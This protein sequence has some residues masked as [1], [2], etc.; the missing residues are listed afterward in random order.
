[1]GGKYAKACW[2]RTALENIVTTSEVNSALSQLQFLK[3]KLRW[4]FI[5]PT[6]CLLIIVLVWSVTFS[7]LATE[8][9]N[10]RKQ[11]FAEAYSLSKSYAEQLSRTVEQVDQITLNVSYYWAESHGALRLEK[12]ANHGLYPTKGFFSIGITDKDGRVLTSLRNSPGVASI[13]DRPYFQAHKNNRISGLHIERLEQ[14]RVTGK[15]IVIVSRSLTDQAGRFAGIVYVAVPPDFLASFYD[16]AGEGEHDALAVVTLDGDFIATK[17][18]KSVRDYGSIARYPAVFS[19]RHGTIAVSENDFFDKRSRIVAWTAL[20]DY[21]FVSVVALDEKEAYA[22]Y[23]TLKRDYTGMAVS[24]TLLLVLVAAIG[25]VLSGRLIWRKHQATI[26]SE[27]YHLAIEGAREGF[28]MARALYSHNQEI[29][30]FVLENFNEHGAQMLG[31]RKE[32][33]AGVRFTQLYAGQMAKRI[34]LIFRKAMHDGFY[35]DEFCMKREEGKVWMHR[36][37]VRSGHGIAITLRDI[38]EAK[39]HERALEELANTDA[40][41]KLPNRYWLSNHLSTLLQ[42]AERAQSNVAVLYFDLDEF[43]DVNNTIGHDAGDDVLVQVGQRIQSVL[44]PGDH[45]VRLGGDEFTVVLSRIDTT[46]DAVRVA[47]RVIE[48]LSTPFQVVGGFEA[49]VGTSI[50]I[51]LYPE[52][53]RTAETLLTHAD[54]AMYAAKNNGKGRF[55]FYSPIL[56]ERTLHR[57]NSEHALRR[58][59]AESQFVL[60]YQPRVAALTGRLVSMEALVRWKHPERGLVPPLDFIPL[61]EETGLI[62][63]IGELVIAQACAQ[64]SEWQENGLKAVP[65]SVNV[66]PIQFARR[67]LRSVIAANISRYGISASMIEVE[68]TESCMLQDS[69]KVALD[70]AGLKTLGIR[71]SVDDFGTGYSSLAQLQRLDIDVLKIDRAFT[72][73][74]ANGK[75]GEAFFKTIVTMAHILDMQVVAEGVETLEQLRIIQ[76][77]GCNEIQGYFVSRPLPAAEAT[78]LLGR[79]TLFPV[80]KMPLRSV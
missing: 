18:G 51:S 1:V 12:Q 8:K 54:T 56:T 78:L 2:I 31:F 32:Q 62:V 11:A 44:R 34:M 58:A 76:S 9:A 43:K 30:D 46:N 74:L 37:L 67:D 59:V 80:G 13:A 65:L 39:R 26:V 73:A 41:T 6:V 40:L 15:P 4:L 69:E 28:F 25:T 68:I 17:M 5:W 38:T 75:H 50:G 48:V 47:N 29:S 21:S 20:D 27:T 24:A 16:K 71:V 3:G 61:A 60:Y 22:T 79:R 49:R 14:G 53:G 70:I 72:E 23:V 33:L 10:I 36:R 63:E 77:L 52:D 57:I 35:E 7:Q 42:R 19:S 66:S 64:I 45:A 55:A